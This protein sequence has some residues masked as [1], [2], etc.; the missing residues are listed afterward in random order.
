MNSHEYDAFKRLA[1]LRRY[2][3][4]LKKVL[5]KRAVGMHVK[6]STALYWLRSNEDLIKSNRAWKHFARRWPTQ[7]AA[8]LSNPLPCECGNPCEQKGCKGFDY[9]GGGC[10]GYPIEEG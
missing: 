9:S 5:A 2:G 3:S 10:P 8:S 4:R 6:P 7:R 1:N